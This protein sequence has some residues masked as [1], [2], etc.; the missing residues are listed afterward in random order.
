MGIREHQSRKR[1]LEILAT[2][3]GEEMSGPACL[4]ESHL[5]A[6][7]ISVYLGQILGTKSP[8]QFIVIDDPVQSMDE[9]HS[10][11]FGEVVKEILQEGY[12]II[13][14]SHQND[15]INMLRNR[16][17]DAP[18]FSDFEIASY[19]KSGP[20]VQERIPAFHNYLE[21]AKKFRAGDATCRAASFNFLRKATER[22]SKDVYMKGKQVSLPKRYESLDT[23]KMEKLL[24]DS[25]VPS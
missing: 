4:S 7:G 8:L 19:D 9:N 2:S 5:N 11:R 14:L 1:W 13:L 15:I 16:F 3:Y 10:T 22:L 25:G 6:V 23:D 24:V 12:Q 18:D 20:K 21:Q 17:Q